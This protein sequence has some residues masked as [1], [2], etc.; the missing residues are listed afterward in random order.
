MNML[1]VGAIGTGNTGNQVIALAKE[2]LN[3]PVMAINS[4]SKD[5]ETIDPSIPS[6]LIS[7]KGGD[8]QGA[9]KNRKLAKTYLKDSI[10]KFLQDNAIN[11]FVMDCDVVFIIG[12][13]GGGTG[14]GTAPVILSVLS[15][16]YPDTLFILVGVGPVESE[17]LSAQV[18]TLEYLN[19]MYSNLEN[20][21]YMLYDNDNYSDEPS[22]RM[23]EHVN[24]EIVN[25]IAV[26]MGMYNTAT[27]Y[28]SIDTEDMMR[29]I[30][31]PGRIVVARVEDIKEKDLDAASIEERLIRTIKESAH[32][33]L[34]RDKKVMGTGLIINL[35]DLLIT[36][37]DS[38]IPKVHEFIGEPVH[39]FLH[40]AINT[41]RKD[42]NS[43]YL[44]MSG[45]S[46]VNDKITKIGERVE[47]IEERQR[48]QEEQSALDNQKLTELG[49]MI[50][51]NDG[52]K[53]AKETKQATVDLEKIFG[54]F[55]V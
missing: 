48:I 5:L 41:D 36:Q 26:I 17:A 15:K 11:N 14:S 28:D 49:N 23:M 44:I 40:V 53:A 50:I 1:K 46:A 21:R 4:S 27:K 47:E 13:T 6:H 34:Q 32:M 8:S 12:S 20:V 42:V 43:V 45:L 22:Y 52:R 7:M 38:H 33:E 3:I 2:K 18:N 37:F 16:T 10:M 54:D 51:Q 25:D 29:L 35:S 30:S 39:E 55:G 19:E 24:A 31:T 9:G